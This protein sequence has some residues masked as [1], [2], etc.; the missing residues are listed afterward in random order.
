MKAF[1]HYLSRFWVQGIGINAFKTSSS[2]VINFT[3]FKSILE[4]GVSM[5]M[6]ISVNMITT[7]IKLIGSVS[8][9]CTASWVFQIQ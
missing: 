2:F 4:Q 3:Q 1:F 7:N 9:K 6:P 5:E 8:V